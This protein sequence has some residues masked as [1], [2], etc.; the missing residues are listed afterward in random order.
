MK[1]QEEAKRIMELIKGETN[2]EVWVVTCDKEA[3]VGSF[4]NGTPANIAMS[5]LANINNVDN[6]AHAN[7]V[8]SIIK[9]VVL[10]MVDNPTDMSVDLIQSLIKKL[11]ENAEEK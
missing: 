4:L 9:N 10:N 6:P 2:A 1:K 8:Y 7:H 11:D 3:G 5:I